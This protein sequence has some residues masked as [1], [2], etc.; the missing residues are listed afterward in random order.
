MLRRMLVCYESLHVIAE[1]RAEFLIST[2]GRG[3]TGSGN[4]ADMAFIDGRLQVT[5]SPF[6]SFFEAN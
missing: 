3:D 4:V 1:F 6:P 2:G 5:C